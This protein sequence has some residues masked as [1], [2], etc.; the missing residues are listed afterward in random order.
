M[1]TAGFRLKINK[2]QFFQPE[3]QYFGHIIDIDEIRPQPEKLK[4]IVEMPNPNNQ[5]EL[6]SFLGMLNYYDRFTPGLASKCTNLND[7]L[8]K[9][10]AWQWDKHHAASVQKIK[11]ALTSTEALAHYD[12]SLPLNLFCD[13]SS[14]CV[15]AVIFHTLPDS[16]EKVIAYASRKLSQAEKKLCSDSK[17]GVSNSLW[18]AEISSVPLWTQI[19]F[20]N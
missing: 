19:L 18:G 16:T 3:V 15:G 11:T 1:K 9:K 2:C 6:H 14:V 17:G 7:L 5:K 13:A 20:N 4:P 8:H 12:P 10:A